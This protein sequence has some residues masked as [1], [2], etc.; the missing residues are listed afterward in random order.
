MFRL[1]V[2]RVEGP[3]LHIHLWPQWCRYLNYVCKD[4]STA[5]SQLPPDLPS[6]QSEKDTNSGLGQLLG[7][8]GHHPRCECRAPP[9]AQG[10][11][12]SMLCSDWFFLRIASISLLPTVLIL[13]QQVGAFRRMEEQKQRCLYWHPVFS[14]LRAQAQQC[15][16]VALSFLASAQSS[17]PPVFGIR[18]AN[19]GFHS[20]KLYR[21]PRPLRTS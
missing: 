14:K 9:A 6:R 18:Q 16:G 2:Y 17:H 8:L 15:Q 19:F 7:D 4:W 11:D 20:K 13:T 1:R 3:Y 10:W 21:S 5:I 12:L